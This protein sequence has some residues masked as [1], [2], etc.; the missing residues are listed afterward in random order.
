VTDATTTTV[1]ESSAIDFNSLIGVQDR[2][3]IITGAGQ[4]IGRVFAH[5][6]AA[7]GAIAVVADL[8]KDKAD[9]VAQE[10]KAMGRKAVAVAVDIGSF[11]SVQAMAKTVVD[12]HGRIDVLVNNA[13]IFSTLEMRPFWEIPLDEWN[14]VLHVNVTGVM[15]ATRAVIPY[16]QERKWGRIINISSASILLGRPNY[17]HYTTSK[18]ALVGMTRSMAR[19]LGNVGI[20]VNAVMPGATQTEIPRK[21]VSPQQREAIVA[22]QCVPRTQAPQDLVGAVVFLAT[23]GSGF[24]TGQVM[25]V[26]GG[27]AHTG[28]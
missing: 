10:I 28:G 19:E 4:G 1:A 13:G 16:M 15:L 12:A 9:A 7:Y 6:F 3:I 14:K 26:D 8:N 17:T 25:N 21:T 2:V 24:M 27:A 23:E 5:A 18:A 20:T 22:R 11:E